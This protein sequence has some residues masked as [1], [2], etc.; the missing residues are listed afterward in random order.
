MQKSLARLLKQLI[1]AKTN[2]LYKLN[3]T[4]FYI[5]TFYRYYESDTKIQ[6]YLKIKNT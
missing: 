3:R 1:K 5:K 2:L 6:K 4:F